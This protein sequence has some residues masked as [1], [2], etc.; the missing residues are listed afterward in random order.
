MK[1]KNF[2]L[3]ALAVA[4]FA[5]PVMALNFEGYQEKVAD[6]MSELSANINDDIAGA[7]D[8][9]TI[10]DV[11]NRINNPER[12]NL[13]EFREIEMFAFYNRNIANSEQYELMKDSIEK[14]HDDILEALIAG[15]FDPKVDMELN[16]T[17]LPAIA[18]Q[19]NDIHSFVL[20]FDV[21]EEERSHKV[22][23]DLQKMDES[24]DGSPFMERFI[25]FINQI[26][27]TIQ[28]DQP[29]VI[30]DQKEEGF[31][32]LN[33]RNTQDKTDI[34]VQDEGGNVLMAVTTD[35]RS[36]AM[37]I[38]NNN[39]NA[40]LECPKN[41]AP[42]LHSFQK[43]PNNRDITLMNALLLTVVVRNLANS[44]NPALAMDLHLIAAWFAL[45]QLSFKNNPKLAFNNL[46]KKVDG[47][48]L[49]KLS[50][51][52]AALLATSLNILNF[53]VPYNNSATVT[54][55][56]RFTKKIISSGNNRRK[57]HS[58]NAVPTPAENI[59]VAE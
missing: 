1:T 45:N 31:L 47:V 12:L 56:E 24:A 28:L 17:T 54:S 48:S 34:I 52:E 18:V 14:G 5:A 57:Q 16:S 37:V 22:L 4:M 29:E 30:Q 41:Y 36:G 8:S 55:L 40:I 49:E 39:G 33:P 7:V 42:V 50:I 51:S 6:I 23:S 3:P 32:P 13:D 15:G 11:R 38:Q 44:N 21:N 10:D 26:E 43:Y 58:M 20:T 19:Y 27:E 25:E 2:L 59:E 35:P 46:S 53:G 9:F